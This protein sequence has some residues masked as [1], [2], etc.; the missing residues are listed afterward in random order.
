MASK[1]TIANM[2]LSHLGVGHEIANVETEQSEEA[3]AIRTFYDT[4]RDFMQSDFPWPFLTRAGSLAL[5]EENPTDE[6]DYSYRYPS[7]AL[8]IHRIFS[9]LRN[10]NRQSRVPHKIYSDSNGKLIYV[11][12]E[13]AIMEYSIK[14]TE[15]DRWPADFTLAFSYLLASYAGP[16]LT[17]GDPYKMRNEALGFYMRYLQLAEQRTLNEEQ[18]EVLPE[19]EFVRARDSDSWPFSDPYPYGWWS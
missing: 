10:D 18:A 13:N 7:D 4:A 12:T 6:W 11:D 5:V 9:S 14:V 19:S 15:E 2:A 16:R 3:A 8:K 1:T 17:K